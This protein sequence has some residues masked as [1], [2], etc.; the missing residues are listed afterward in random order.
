MTG[1]LK[2]ELAD[3]IKK[4]DDA[5][6]DVGARL[7]EINMIIDDIIREIAILSGKDGVRIDMNFPF[8][9]K[10]EY[11][12][13]M[14]VRV[15]F[16]SDSEQVLI[17]LSDGRQGIAWTDLSLSV[18]DMLANAVILKLAA[19]TIYLDLQKH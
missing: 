5:M 18:K 9:E 15:F 10:G 7:F 8:C 3:K 2:K 11:V 19:D 1:K 17:E 12:S 14:A 6:V 16:D 4:Y 13:L